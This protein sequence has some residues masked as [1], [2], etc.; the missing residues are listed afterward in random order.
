MTNSRASLLIN[1][2]FYWLQT[3]LHVTEQLNIECNVLLVHKQQCNFSIWRC[4][5]V[6]GECN[7]SVVQ[8]IVWKSCKT[9]W[10]LLCCIWMEI[11]SLDIC[12]YGYIT[13]RHIFPWKYFWAW[14]HWWQKMHLYSVQNEINHPLWSCGRPPGTKF[15]RIQTF[16]ANMWTRENIKIQ[17]PQLWLAIWSA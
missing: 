3:C 16:S 17:I 9:V 15:Y 1:K 10:C 12:T 6:T 14:G 5:F 11:F 13:G 2:T 7:E 4:H 8:Q